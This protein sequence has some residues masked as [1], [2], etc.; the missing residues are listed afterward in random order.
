MSN[1]GL[2]KIKTETARINGS[3]PYLKAFGGRALPTPFIT[4]AALPAAGRKPAQP[5]SHPGR[6]GEQRESTDVD[7]EPCS[8]LWGLGEVGRYVTA[9][10]AT[11]VMGG[12]WEECIKEH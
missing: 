5:L 10:S 11:T 6:R 9:L 2:V 4:Q 7:S 1:K 12:S 3:P 8:G